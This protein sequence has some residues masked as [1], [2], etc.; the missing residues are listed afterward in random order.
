MNE[1]KKRGKGFPEERF[2]HITKKTP[3]VKM[4]ILPGELSRARSARPLTQ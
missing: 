1:Y 2:S 3:P 4:I